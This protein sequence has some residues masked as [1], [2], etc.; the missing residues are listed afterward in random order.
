MIMGEAMPCNTI[1]F[2]AEQKILSSFGSILWLWFITRFNYSKVPCYKNKELFRTITY[3]VLIVE[4]FPKLLIITDMFS[5]IQQR[6]LYI[7]KMPAIFL[8][9]L[10][11]FALENT[12]P[13]DF[14]IGK[15]YIKMKPLNKCITLTLQTMTAKTYLLWLYSYR[16]NPHSAIM[17]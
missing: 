8:Q 11:Q 16:F 5:F 13:T 15:L 12:F 4:D 3:K 9:R 14:F 17:M 7:G 2:W 6:F 1:S 10:F